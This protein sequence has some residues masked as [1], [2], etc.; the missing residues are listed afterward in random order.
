MAPGDLA[1]DLLFDAQTDDSGKVVD[2][3]KHD[4]NLKKFADFVR[5]MP[6][7]DLAQAVGGNS[8]LQLLDPTRNTISYLAVL[9]AMKNVALKTRSFL[10]GQLDNTLV[11]LASFDAVQARYMGPELRELVFWLASYYD[12][13]TDASVI[14]AIGSAI[15]Q[16][17]PTGSTFTSTHLLFVR[18]CLT[19]GLPRQALPVLDKDIYNF[20][21][22]PIKG[23]DDIP[24]C[25]HHETSATYITRSSG[26]AGDIAPADVQEYYLLGAQVYIGLRQW[27]RATLFLELVLASP[28]SHVATPLMV[29]AYKKLILTT[30]LS[31]GQSFSAKALLDQQTQKS[32]SSLSKAYEGLADVFKNRD[33][34]RFHAEVDMATQ[35]FTED[36]NIGLVNQVAESLRRYRVIDLQ[37]TYSALPVQ[38]IAVHLSLSPEAT[39]TLLTAMIRDRHIKATLPQSTGD[40]T[41]T[42]AST[43]VLRFLSHNPNHT[44]VGLDQDTI[45]QAKYHQIQRLSKHVKEADRKLAIS[46]EYVHFIYRSKRAEGASGPYE[47]TL[48]E[49]WDGPTAEVDEDMMADLR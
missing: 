33:I 1:S 27:A 12:S 26:L 43:Q 5:K 4:G 38:R 35:L 13:T 2:V 22:D 8:L 7:R 21:S 20:P 31:T 23:V 39:I 45:L 16:L 32:V 17:D 34:Q 49:A 18:Y 29:E 30:L 11:F 42:N 48:E 9:L 19:A 3:E 28:T 40:L 47:E 25:A 6:E 14:P 10:P 46:K 37:N 36:G 15:L 41:N 24:L 44:P